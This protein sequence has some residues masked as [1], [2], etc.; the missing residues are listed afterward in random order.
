MIPLQ[1]ELP[2]ARP[3]DPFSIEFARDANNLVALYSAFDSHRRN[4]QIAFATMYVAIAAIMLLSAVWL[5]LSFANR[6][7]A[8]I[9]RLI[10]ATDQVSS[11]N[12]YVQV[13]VG[14]ADSD[15]AHLGSTFN[16]MTGV[17]RSQHNSLVAANDIKT[18]TTK[19]KAGEG[20]LGAVINDPTVYEDLK[21]V[22]G[23]VKRNR[24][25]RELVRYSISNGESLDKTGKPEKK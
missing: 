23:N 11:G 9:R 18:I 14:S 21:E 10:A 16:N 5:G 20:T 3:V 19:I 8:P 6:L 1:P 22:L 17:L 12:L 25:L 2:A 24:V 7:V 15:I 4:I 13:P